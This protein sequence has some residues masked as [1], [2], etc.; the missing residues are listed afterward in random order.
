MSLYTEQQALIEFF[1]LEMTL[2]VIKPNHQHYQVHVPSIP[3]G[4]A[5]ATSL[6]SLFQHLIT[7]PVKKFFLIAHL[8]LLWH[9]LRPSPCILKLLNFY[10]SPSL[11]LPLGKLLKS[12]QPKFRSLKHVNTPVETISWRKLERSRENPRFFGY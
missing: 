2:K 1:R 6:G 10:S 11:Q 7:L 3:P 4:I 8:I 9:I 5:T 12:Q